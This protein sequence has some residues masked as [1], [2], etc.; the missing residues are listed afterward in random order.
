MASRRPDGYVRRTKSGKWV[1]EIDSNEPDLKRGKGRKKRIYKT[2]TGTKRDA[3][4]VKAQMIENRDALFSGK[5]TL[6]S[7]ITEYLDNIAPLK[8]RDRTLQG[9]R[10]IAETHLIPSIGHL[11]IKNLKP[12]HIQTYY[13]QKGKEGRRDGLGGLS[14]RTIRSHH[15]LLRL[16]I[17]HAYKNEKL[18]KNVMELVDAPT[19][20]SKEISYLSME[21]VNELVRES[22]STRYFPFVLLA[23]NT[24]MRLSEILGLQWRDVDLNQKTIQIQRSSVY[25][26]GGKQK[27]DKPKSKSGKR[28]IDIDPATNQVLKDLKDASTLKL[29]DSFCEE[30]PVLVES[31]GKPWRNDGITKGVKKLLKKIGRP[32][33]SVHGLRHTF[34]SHMMQVGI[35]MKVV[36]ELLGHSDFSITANIYSHV[37]AGLQ[38]Q[39]VQKL[40]EARSNSAISPFFPRFSPDSASKEVAI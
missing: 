6:E 8:C 9:Y 14:A 28:R 22:Y 33:V 7:L 39:A 37:P 21:Q 2:I 31:D 23:S 30:T 38:I 3:E 34:A 40:A 32:D 24:G 5:Q 16:V 36:Q 18:H 1:I 25:L 27:Y 26:K 17:N 35:N 15:A 11:Q 10:S 20:D 29:G 19:A 4:R 12:D 13:T